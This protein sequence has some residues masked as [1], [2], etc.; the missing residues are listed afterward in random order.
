MKKE[1]P[2]FVVCLRNTGY[3]ASL[4]RRKLYRVLRP[5]RHDPEESLRVVD[6]SGEDYLYP[7]EWFAPVELDERLRRAIAR[8]R[9]AAL[10]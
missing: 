2:R 10:R 6:E 4:E 7:R 9:D 5:K 3:Q 1:P 8:S